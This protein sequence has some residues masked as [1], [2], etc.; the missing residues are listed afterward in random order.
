MSTGTEDQAVVEFPGMESFYAARGG[1]RSPESDYGGYNTYDLGINPLNPRVRPLDLRYRVSYVDDTGD[2]Y[3]VAL[4]GGFAAG[5]H[6][7][8]LG[9]VGPGHVEKDVHAH[10]GD[11]AE[12][13]GLGRPLSWFKKRI[14]TFAP[15]RLTDADLPAGV[16]RFDSIEVFY[17]AR[18]GRYSG[19][20]GFGV[21]NR[22]DLGVRLRQRLESSG[23]GLVFIPHG[24]PNYRVSY[25]HDTGDFYAVEGRFETTAQVA[26]LGSVGPGHEEPEVCMHFA[27]WAQGDGPGRP[28][29][30]FVER[31]ASFPSS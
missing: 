23:S 17:D 28:F 29:S 5:A 21:F 6:V 3:A 1:E 9:S 11:W 10:F 14:R 13:E 16:G 19:E 26:L 20:S 24:E 22:D 8:L 2:F 15:E 18:G 31:I 4:V 27:D 12:G 7:I 25:V 30:W